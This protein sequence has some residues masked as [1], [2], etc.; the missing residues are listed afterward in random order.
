[1]LTCPVPAATTSHSLGH[2]RTR[3]LSIP[4]PPPRQRQ[5]PRAIVE[6]LNKEFTAAINTPQVRDALLIQGLQAETTTSAAFARYL[7]AEISKWRE[8]ARKA[9]LKP[10]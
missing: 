2:H 9:D 8:V 3:R 6:R 5:T 7:D 10:G 4:A 1:M